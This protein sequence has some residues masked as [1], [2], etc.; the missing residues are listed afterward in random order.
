[1]GAVEGKGDDEGTIIWRVEC[2]KNKELTFLTKPMG[3]R[4]QRREWYRN[5]KKYIGKYI[6]V[7]YFDMDKNTGCVTRFPVGIKIIYNE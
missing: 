2:L 7:K 1:M 6:E 4:E 3:T 5:R